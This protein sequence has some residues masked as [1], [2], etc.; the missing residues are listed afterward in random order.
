[1]IWD[2]MI[3]SLLEVL[4]LVVEVALLGLDG[5]RALVAVDQAAVEALVVAEELLQRL[6]GDGAAL[7]VNAALV[8]SE[9]GEPSLL[10]EDGRTT[11]VAVVLAVVAADLE[12][13]D[14][15]EQHLE[16]LVRDGAALA[17]HE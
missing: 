5:Q 9:S 4:A 13:V 6:L 16:R 11:P 2:S 3:V 17:V 15:A 1:M 12:L 7:A 10:S 14:G 8:A